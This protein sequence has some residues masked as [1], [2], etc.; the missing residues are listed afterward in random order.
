VARVLVLLGGISAEHPI[1]CL[2]GRAVIGAIDP[3]RHDV[4]AVGITR[5]G[6][7]TLGAG[8]RDGADGLPEVDPDAPGCRLEAGPDGPRLVADDGTAVGAAL[9]VAFPVL[10]GVGGED[11]T[12]QR[13]LAAAGLAV[14]GAGPEASAIG[15]DKAAMKAAFE[16][17]G[18]PRTPHVVVER[19]DRDDPAARAAIA[20]LVL[21][22][23]VKPA[24]QG[25]SIGITR[26]TDAGALAGALDEAFAHDD[27]ALVEAAVPGAR[28][29]EVGVLERDGVVEVTR[30]GEIVPS[31]AFY[32]F[33]AKYL[34]DSEL[35]V[36]ADVDAGVV[37]EAARLARAAF[38]AIGA[39]GMA[40]VDLFLGTDG[41]LVVNEINTI[42]GFTERSMFPRLWAAEGVGFTE[43][44][45][46]LLA[47][48]RRG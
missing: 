20:A 23:F 11:G 2:S 24:R 31:H 43:L 5:A 27:V 1:S 40:R 12:V 15:V 21:P 37:A 14:V 48:A 18:L 8:T 44:V 19:A 32:D 7:W 25:S 13:E 41:R 6:R 36:P 16:R 26:V 9:D 30:P 10:H 29:L 47:A 22:W 4:V 34:D 38:A 28:E 42:P 17:A 45:E 3:T 39:S 35:V 46:R 33:E